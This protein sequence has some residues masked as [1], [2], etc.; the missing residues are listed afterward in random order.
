MRLENFK[1]VASHSIQNYLQQNNFTIFFTE[2]ENGNPANK[3][4]YPKNSNFS[5]KKK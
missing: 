3:N 5:K 2:L 1:F 4:Y